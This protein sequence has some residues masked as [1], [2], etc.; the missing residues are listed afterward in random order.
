M[1]TTHSHQTRVWGPANAGWWLV[2]ALFACGLLLRVW[3][4]VGR[5]TA[6]S[7]EVFEYDELARNVLAGKGFLYVHHGTAYRSLHSCWPYVLLTAA[8]YAV[9]GYVPAAMLIIQAL[10]S[11]ALALVIWRMGAWC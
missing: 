2:M 11:M 6:G 3:I 5:G 9:V 10:V 1:T 4:M 8:T 7:P